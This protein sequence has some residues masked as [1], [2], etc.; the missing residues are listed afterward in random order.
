M[1][2]VTRAFVAVTEWRKTQAPGTNVNS[3]INSVDHQL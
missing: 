2:L 3:L 1:N